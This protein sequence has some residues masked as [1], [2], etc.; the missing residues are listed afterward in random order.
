MFTTIPAIIVKLR[1]DIMMVSG[2]LESTL[3]SLSL[4]GEAIDTKVDIRSVQATLHSNHSMLL[5]NLRDLAA[6]VSEQILQPSIPFEWSGSLDFKFLELHDQLGPWVKLCELY[7]NRPSVLAAAQAGASLCTQSLAAT[8][9]MND[10]IAKIHMME[11]RFFP[12][13]AQ[14]IVYATS[15]LVDEVKCILDSI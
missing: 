10:M 9:E 2:L 3:H 14:R 8:I 1:G 4:F 12:E 11:T 13:F 15:R 5:M 6:T 7:S